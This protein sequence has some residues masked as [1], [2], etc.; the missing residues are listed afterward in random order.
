MKL[1]PCTIEG[2]INVIKPPVIKFNTKYVVEAMAAIEMMI[3]SMGNKC[4]KNM[5]QQTL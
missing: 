3:K 4:F 2:W 1:A 5:H